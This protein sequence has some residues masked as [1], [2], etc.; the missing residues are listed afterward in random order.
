[1]T[2][3]RSNIPELQRHFQALAESADSGCS[4]ADLDRIW[5]AVAG[6]LP[7]AERIALVERLVIDPAFAEAWRVAHA[8][9]RNDVAVPVVGLRRRARAPAWLAAA[10]VALLAVSVA[11]VSRLY[12]PVGDTLRTPGATRIESLVA[13]DAALSRDAFRLR[14]SPGPPGSRY[15]VRATTEDLQVLITV[16]NLTEPEVTIDPAALAM[17]TPGSRVLWQVEV[18]LPTGERETS[19][20]FAAR[21]Q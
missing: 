13:T 16:V 19:P 20:T 17:L 11:L 15:Q 21:V 18:T 5:R 6:G 3:R 7:A 12:L 10:A 14:W 4:A 2:E 1:M 9:G 8:L